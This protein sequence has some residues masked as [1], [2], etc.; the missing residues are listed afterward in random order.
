VDYHALTAR[1]R[2]ILE[3]LA[4]GKSNKEIASILLISENTIEYHL[5]K[6]IY[7]LLQ[8]RTRSAAAAV[9][10]NKSFLFVQYPEAVFV[11]QLRALNTKYAVAWEAQEEG[12]SKLM[13]R[14]PQIDRVLQAAY[15]CEFPACSTQTVFIKEL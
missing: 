13:L 1:Q 11:G 7:P 3:L 6:R 2:R 15:E 9:Y 12:W 10:F 4:S 14:T 5:V 8:V